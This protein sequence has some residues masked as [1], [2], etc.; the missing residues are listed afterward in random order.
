M[1]EFVIVLV[2][3]SAVGR[4]ISRRPHH[5]E[6]RGELPPG[7]REELER[8]RGTVEDLSGRLGRLEEERDFYKDLL[9]GPGTHRAIPPPEGRD[10]PSDTAGP[11]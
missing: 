1:F 11:S 2:L 8:I 3:I 6:A 9:D 4:A 10:S 7:G 5:R